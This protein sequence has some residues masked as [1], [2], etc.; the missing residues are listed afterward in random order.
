MNFNSFKASSICASFT[1]IVSNEISA[2]RDASLVGIFFFRPEHTYSASVG[3]SATS[4]DLMLVDEEDCVRAFDIVR[5]K[6]F[7]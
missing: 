1:R 4:G 7:S 2:C 3:D 6:P 5:R